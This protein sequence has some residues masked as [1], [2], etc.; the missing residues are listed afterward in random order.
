MTEATEPHTQMSVFCV[1]IY[2]LALTVSCLGTYPKGM[3]AHVLADLP[4][5]LLIAVFIIAKG[6]LD[7]YK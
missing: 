4:I 3:Q 6:N 5:S 1:F 7:L 2:F